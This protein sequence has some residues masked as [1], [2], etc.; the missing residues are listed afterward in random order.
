MKHYFD[1]LVHTISALRDPLTGCPWDLQQTHTSLAPYLTEE[2]FELVHALHN[3]DE[4]EQAEELGDVLL[5]VLLHAQLGNEESKYNM[6]EVCEGLNEKLIRRHPHV[7]K[8]KNSQISLEE[9]DAQ[10]EKIKEE[11][12]KKTDTLLESKLLNYSALTSANKIGKKTHKISFD[13]D[14]PTEVLA[15]VESELDELKS[16]IKHEGKARINEEMGDLLFSVAQLARHLDI[17]PEISLHDANNKFF[18]RFTQLLQLVERDGLDFLTLEK[19][20]KEDYWE[21][22]KKNEKNL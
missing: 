3:G 7:F 13:W 15:Q 4:K 14:N 10:W 16:A 17:D 18:R 2:C 12:G 19:A 11:E 8:E 1:K 22:V 20:Q 21:K 6:K 9:L 5:Q